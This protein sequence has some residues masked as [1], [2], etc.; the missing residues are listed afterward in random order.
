MLKTVGI[1]PDDAQIVPPEI[2]QKLVVRIAGVNHF[3]WMFKLEYDGKDYLPKYREQVTVGVQKEKERL[4]AA[5]FEK[6]DLTGASK[7]RYSAA[8]AL[9]LLDIFKAYP[10]RIV[11]T[12]E[13]VPWF[14]GYGKAPV[15]PEPITIFDAS[16]RQAKV[17]EFHEE[18]LAWA[19]GAKPIEEFI[20]N[21]G[22][23][24]ATDIIESM[25]GGLGK[26]F[27]INTPNHGA[28]TNL[29]DDAFLESRCDVDMNGPRPM[30]IGPMPLGLRGL[31]QQVLDTHELTA[32]AAMEFDRNALLQAMIVD[33]IVNN[34]EDAEAIIE[35][36]FA[37]QKDALDPKWY[38]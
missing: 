20:K 33:P 6:T 24:H 26:P 21:G 22:P 16:E 19:D 17:D 18:T 1:L 4:D 3:T 30:P 10:N 14:Q 31:T 34:I 27:F 9:R 25:W 2:R 36:T 13:Y 8:Y 12:K 23:D 38:E 35:E 32:K 15:Q 28:V 5:L 11:H 7:R 37:R 29:P